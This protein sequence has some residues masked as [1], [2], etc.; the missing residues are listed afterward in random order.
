MVVDRLA[1]ERVLQFLIHCRARRVITVKSP[2]QGKVLK[3]FNAV[4]QSVTTFWMVTL[5]FLLIFAEFCQ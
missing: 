5:E 3:F 4:T 1:R 2:N